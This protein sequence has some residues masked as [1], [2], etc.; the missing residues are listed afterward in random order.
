MTLVPSCPQSMTSR[1]NFPIPSNKSPRRVR[2]VW[3]GPPSWMHGLYHHFRRDPD[4]TALVRPSPFVSRQLR[5][6]QTQLSHKNCTSLLAA[7]TPLPEASR[8]PCSAPTLFVSLDA[9]KA[10]H[11]GEVFGLGGYCHGLFFSLLLSASTRRA[12]SIA[13]LELMALVASIATFH[14]FS[15]H[16][17]RV[18]LESDSLP[19]TFHLADERATDEA[20]QSVL[21]Y[22]H[23]MPAFLAA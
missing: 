3:V 8:A 19:A 13:T 5:R 9:A 14:A 7:A 15:R 17:P 1:D 18:V 16:F 11:E 12:N 10:Y 23:A 22:L 4:P 21:E 6:W 20:A 2:G